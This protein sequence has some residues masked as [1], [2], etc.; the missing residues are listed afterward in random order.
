M[1]TRLRQRTTV[2]ASFRRRK[3]T[4]STKKRDRP[5]SSAKTRI[6]AAAALIAVAGCAKKAPPELPP[7]PPTAGWRA[8]A[9]SG[10]HPRPAAHA[11]HARRRAAAP[12]SSSR[13]AATASSLALDLDRIWIRIPRHAGRAGP[14]AA[15]LSERPRHDR[16]PLRRARHARIQPAL[17]D[18][19][20]NAAK[21]Y[22]VGKGIDAGRPRRSATARAPGRPRPT[23]RAGSRTARAVTWCANKGRVSGP[24][25]RAA[26]P[27]AGVAARSLVLADEIG[28]ALPISRAD[29]PAAP[30]AAPPRR[31]PSG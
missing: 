23:R 31:C 2:P 4:S 22:L 7:P 18:R 10:I 8:G 21:N 6:L 3:R 1:L 9:C 15:A 16:G 19:R 13:P 17:G 30:A 24:R 12:I 25:I 26:I 29:S 5:M 20:A 14:V 11:E 28:R 27:S